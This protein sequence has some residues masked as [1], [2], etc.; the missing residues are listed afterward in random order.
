MNARS[1]TGSRG[2]R[3]YRLGMVGDGWTVQ[4]Q[5][6]FIIVLFKYI[7]KLACKIAYKFYT[8]SLWI[9][10]NCQRFIQLP[11]GLKNLVSSSRGRVET[12]NI[13]H[14]VDISDFSDFSMPFSILESALWNY[15]VQLF[16]GKY[17][18][19]KRN[20]LWSIYNIFLKVF[21]WMPV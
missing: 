2:C 6:P 13:T 7:S 5:G 20:V 8:T 12:Q 3:R 16:R 11:C 17:L 14:I 10:K 19:N 15:V 18:L 1:A 21:L 4:Q 9:K